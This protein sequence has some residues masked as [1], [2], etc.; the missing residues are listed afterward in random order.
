M[1]RGL[2]A[3]FVP[4]P[5]RGHPLLPKR[6]CLRREIVDNVKN[7]AILS[8]SKTVFALHRG[9]ILKTEFMEPRE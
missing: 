2:A 5:L 7:G 4:L 9:E 3:G 1:G 8:R 6:S